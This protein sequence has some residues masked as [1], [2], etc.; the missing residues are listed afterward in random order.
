MVKALHAAYAA[1]LMH[2]SHRAKAV[3]GQFIFAFQ[4]MKPSS[5]DNSV[6]ILLHFAY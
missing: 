1:E 6:H 3:D 2:R 5:G 4:E